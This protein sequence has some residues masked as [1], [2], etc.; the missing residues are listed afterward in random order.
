MT[1]ISVLIQDYT[2][3][4]FTLESLRNTCDRGGIQPRD[5][6]RSEFGLYLYGFLESPKQLRWGYEPPRRLVH[7]GQLLSPGR[8]IKR[9]LTAARFLTKDIL[10]GIVMMTEYPLS[11]V[12]NICYIHAHSATYLDCAGHSQSNACIIKPRL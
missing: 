11:M 7:E 2:M 3:W 4:Y 8:I 6:Q 1:D 5:Y 10:L 9:D 12:F